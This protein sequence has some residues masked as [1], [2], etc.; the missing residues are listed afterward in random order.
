MDVENAPV[1]VLN[2]HYQPIHLTSV[3]RAFIMLYLDQA[4]AVDR[5]YRVFDFVRWSAQDA[6]PQDLVLHTTK[7]VFRAPRVILLLTYERIPIGR[8]RFSRSNIFARDNHTCQYCHRQMKRA[9]LNLD[10]VM[11]KSRG[12]RTSW[13]NVVTSCVPCNLRKG[14]RTPEE[15]R[16]HLARAASR[17][18]W[19]AL[20][21]QPLQDTVQ[22]DANFADWRPYL[23]LTSPEA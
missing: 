8:V 12:G 14:N 23:N 16:M 4:H 5:E 6:T 3:R 22:I 11:P 17:P 10:H 20:I 9:E 21:R 1:L 7:K 13:E 2:R 19:S 15:A 18:K